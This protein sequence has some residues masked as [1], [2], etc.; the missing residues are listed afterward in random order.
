PFVITIEQDFNKYSVSS[1]PTLAVVG[2][3]GKIA[4]VTVGAGSE[5]L[6]KAAVKTL[7]KSN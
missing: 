1:I 5:S 7:L 6:L 2:K 4:L 3:D